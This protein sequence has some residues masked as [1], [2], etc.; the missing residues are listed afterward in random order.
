MGISYILDIVIG[1][2]FIYLILSLLASEIQELL[3][4][5]LQWRAVHLKQSIEGLLNG[6]EET[7]F[8]KAKELANKIYDNPLIK[9]I[10]H[11]AK[12][13]VEK[14]VRSIGDSCGKKKNSSDDSDGKKK[15]GVFGGNHFSGPSSIGKQT[16]ASALLETLHL[17]IF[18]KILTKL[19]LENFIQ[20]KLLDASYSTKDNSAYDRFENIK[21]KIFI[22]Y[23]NDDIDIISVINKLYE[24]SLNI[25]EILYDSLFKDVSEKR[26]LGK[27]KPSML[28]AVQLLIFYRNTEI[29]DIYLEIKEKA[30]K[31]DGTIDYQLFKDATSEYFRDNKKYV[32]KEYISRSFLFFATLNSCS[33][34]VNKEIK[35]LT[36]H[37]SILLKIPE[38]LQKSLYNLAKHS[39]KKFE[40]AESQLQI[41]QIELEN[42]FDR[43]MIRAGGVYKR[44]SRLVALIIGFVIAI[45]ANADTFHIVDRLAKDQV[46][47]QSVSQ[48]AEKIIE[49]SKGE[50]TKE[51]QKKLED[52]ANQINLP[53]GWNEANRT[54]SRFPK[55][56]VFSTKNANVSE[57][58]HYI[59]L[60]SW[61]TIFGWIISAIAISM[62]S[63]F[64]FDLLGRFID[65]KN[66]G[67][68]TTE[69]DL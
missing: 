54:L 14:F 24:E 49:Q 57:T 25:N 55:F 32:D 4:T 41:F 35:N 38:P 44:N 6:N 53:M 11:S 10:N 13:K 27:I 5:L 15:N 67:K 19:K 21:H 36:R 3:N 43:S 66:I 8:N 12:G 52:A 46:L 26:L 20:Q 56:E 42:W 59:Y 58:K 62:G 40:A 51:T 17:E 31:K 64:W 48:S 37:S 45:V 39:Q 63:S 60:P 7:E 50:L 34:Y 29:Q 1:L 18:I 47:R 68:K 61:L 69:K 9:D 28:D 16:F 22:F 65:V 2:F 33:S 30:K 23:D